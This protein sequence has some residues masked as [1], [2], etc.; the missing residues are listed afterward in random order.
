VVALTG[1]TGEIDLLVLAPSSS[2][3]ELFE[4]VG[5][6]RR[7]I[8]AVVIDDSGGVYLRGAAEWR[9]DRRTRH[10]YSSITR[11]DG[12]VTESRFG[13]RTPSC[14]DR[15][16]L[17]VPLRVR[18]GALVRATIRD[19]WKVGDI[20]PTLCVS[21]P[22]GRASCGTIPIGERSSRATRAFRPRKRGHWRVVLRGPSQRLR[23][24]VAVGVRSRSQDRGHL[25]MVVLAGDSF[26][27][28]L[29]PPLVDRLAGRART[30][31]RVLGGSGLV[32]PD[33]DW[34]ALARRQVRR[35]RPDV[36]VLMLGGADGFDMTTPEG[37]HVPC[38]EEPWIA[39]YS[40]RVQ[41]LT[42]IYARQGA[43][44][45]VWILL[46]APRSAELRSNFAAVNEAIR[47]AVQ[48]GTRLVDLPALLTPGFQYREAIQRG[49]RRVRVRSEDGTHFTVAGASISAQRVLRVLRPL[50]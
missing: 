32:D 19:R 16:S 42:E 12:S 37:Q 27:S 22:G 48:G 44:P 2:R 46:P 30:H 7:F 25:P 10:F 13:I 11:P 23:A 20:R 45:V 6:H 1:K 47:R 49:G 39:E 33:L 36:T 41:E 3:V 38:C 24:S 14:R 17:A 29:L 18:P 50:L 8:T 4:E 28:Q 9:C 34:L 15:L 21:P 31:T 5:S 40:R 43:A 26:M 35:V